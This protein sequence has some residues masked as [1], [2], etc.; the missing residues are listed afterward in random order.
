MKIAVSGKVFAIR[1]QFRNDRR[2][3][4]VNERSNKKFYA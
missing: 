1:P 4:E 3:Y 2:H